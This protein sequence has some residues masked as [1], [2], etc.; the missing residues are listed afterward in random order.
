MPK[1]TIITPVWYSK[2]DPTNERQPRYEMFL[3]CIKSLENQTFKDFEWVIADDICTP[4]VEDLLKELKPNLDWRVI[5]LPEKSG[6]I[7]ARNAAM[8]E[9][10]GEWICWLDGDDE[11]AS[12]YLQAFAKAGEIYSEYNMFSQHH[13][14]FHHD[15]STEV[16]RFID[17]EKLEGRPFG[18][19]TIGAG[20]YVFK[21][22]L[23]EKVGGI[24]EKG[25]WDLATWAYETYPE[26]KP[27]FWNENKQGYNSLGNPWGEDYLYF[28]MLAKHLD[29]KVKHLNTAL[30]LVHSHYGEKWQDDPEFGD[31]ESKKPEYNRN[32]I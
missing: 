24:P 13:L 7:V 17:V 25:L 23:F 3:R 14:V 6:R 22:E 30:Y 29:W 2:D 19:G 11:Y 18:S 26:I 28:Y 32:L 5:R 10:K 20:A 15:Y 9:A 1:F 27:F 31:S 8:K 12:I 21:R 4:P 16:R